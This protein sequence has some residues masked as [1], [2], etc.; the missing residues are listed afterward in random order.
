MKQNLLVILF[1]LPSIA[2]AAFKGSIEFTL[3]EIY[4]HPIDV[5]TIVPVAAD[6]LKK[7]Y[8]HHLEFHRLHGISPFYGDQSKF[9]KLTH[10]QRKEFLRSIGKDENL[11]D[12]MESISCVGLALRCLSRGFKAVGKEHIWTRINDHL[13]LNAVDGT[14]L[15]YSM[16]KLGWKTLYWNPDVS[17][18]AEW[19]NQEKLRNPENNYR[20]WGW[21]VYRWYTLGKNNMYYDNPVDDKTTLVNFGIKPPLIF[22]KLPFFLGTAHTGYHVFL[23]LNGKIIE[24]H[25]LRAITDITTL[26]YSEFN[27]LTPT[28]GPQGSMYSGLMAVPPGYGI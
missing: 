16:R 26:E 9:G 11:V 19:D 7:S 17:M 15:Q 6:C 20:S 25:S 10:Q 2:L 3:E 4:E 23:G 21:H 1:L 13:R 5:N 27:P 28:G 8:A 12:K 18:N 14:A 22:K 24:G